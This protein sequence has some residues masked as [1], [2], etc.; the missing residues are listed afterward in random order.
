K[1]NSLKRA[2]REG[3]TPEN[4]G[5]RPAI[6]EER[7]EEALRALVLIFED[8]EARLPNKEARILELNLLDSL[9]QRGIKHALAVALIDRMINEGVFKTEQRLYQD[10][11]EWTS[12]HGSKTVDSGT[13]TGRALLITPQRWHAFLA[14]QS[15]DWAPKAQ[16]KIPPAKRTRPM[17]LQ[18]A[19][20]Y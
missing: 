18:E 5:A 7:I 2:S 13:R 3:E 11:R 17:S 6:S 19:A 10:I 4:L 15:I 20:R 12:L 8:Q 16:N 9:R 1:S 14:R